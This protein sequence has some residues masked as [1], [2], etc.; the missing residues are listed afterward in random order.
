MQEN[1]PRGARGGHG[2]CALVAAL[3]ITGSVLTAAT[4]SASD[5][6]DATAWTEP[7][8]ESVGTA[9]AAVAPI[10]AAGT[11][12]ALDTTASPPA[13]VAPASPA[14]PAPVIG[15][16]PVENGSDPGPSPD[17]ATPTGA[18]AP[19][20]SDTEWSVVE[21]TVAVAEP[22]EVS[23]SSE[24][25]ST[26]TSRTDATGGNEVASV[27][28]GSR[29]SQRTVA[30]TQPRVE[31]SESKMTVHVSETFTEDTAG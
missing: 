31:R 27:R 13:P 10:A 12:A 11:T 9:F 22:S 26:V 25:A 30:E 7:E 18:S 6:P 3:L 16:P 21:S 19:V 1:H 8:I 5:E 29:S 24:S 28:T 2:G 4:A 14:E 17:D 23:A 20:D 15:E